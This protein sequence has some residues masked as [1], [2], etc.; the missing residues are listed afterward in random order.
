MAKNEAEYKQ[1]IVVRQDLKLSKGKMAAQASHASVEATLRSHK[2]D[3]TAWRK[4]GMKKS[5]LKVP[6]KKELMIIKSEA[7]EEGLVTAVI[8]DAGKTQIL[9]GSITCVGIGPAK[10][11]K[12]DKVTG[13]L[14]LIS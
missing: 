9:P 2:D 10:S 14:K 6:D 4:Q 8:T 11:E 13:H 12:I 5:V 3:I 1:V 7:E